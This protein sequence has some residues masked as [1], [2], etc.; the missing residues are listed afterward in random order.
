[1]QVPAEVLDEL[2]RRLVA[3]V[4]PTRIILFGSA[5]RGEMHENSDLDVLVVVP[6]G[7]SEREAW[8]LAYSGLRRFGFATDLV[9][10]NE[11]ILSKYGKSPGMVYEQALKD[12]KELYHAA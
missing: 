2:V 4:Q 10:V 8:N 7:L 12:G 11:S 5:A 9:V 3:A 1:M 6:D